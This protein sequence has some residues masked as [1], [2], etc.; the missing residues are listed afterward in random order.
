MVKT[1]GYVYDYIHKGFNKFN[2]NSFYYMV[3]TLESI[4]DNK[5]YKLIKHQTFNYY[6]EYNYNI[7][8]YLKNDQP[9]IIIFNFNNKIIN[10]NKTYLEFYSNKILYFYYLPEKCNI[11]IKMLF[12]G[13]KDGFKKKIQ[14]YFI[15]LSYEIADVDDDDIGKDSILNKIKRNLEIINNYYKIHL[16][17]LNQFF[18]FDLNINYL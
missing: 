1:D 11:K 3:F 5:V 14:Q 13:T 12:S 2:K 6:N 10:Q 7:I 8:N 17:N 18:I 4:N 15:K 16:K 9:Y